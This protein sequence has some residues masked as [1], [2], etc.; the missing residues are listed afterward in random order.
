MSIHEFLYKDPDIVPEEAPL[1]ILDSKYAVCIAKTGKGTN[2]TRNIPRRVNFVRNGENWKMNKIDWCEGGLQLADISTKNVGKND[3]K[4]QNEIYYCNN[5]HLRQNTCK[6][7]VTGYRI[8]YE[9]IFLYDYT[10]LSL[11]LDSMSLTCLYQFW[12]MKRTL[13]L[14]YYRRKTMLFWMENIV[15]RKPCK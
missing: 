7:R 1:I 15:E 9:T 5:W 14:V 4:F 13:K 6:R 10:R 8:L 11:V 3:L 12:Y 2:H